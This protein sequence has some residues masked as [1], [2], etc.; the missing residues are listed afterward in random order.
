LIDSAPH[1]GTV[2]V[3]CGDDN[4]MFHQPTTAF[5]DDYQWILQ[6]IAEGKYPHTGDSL[7]GIDRVREVLEGVIK[8][9]E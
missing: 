8:S 2:A 9:L 3:N 5:V 7:P 4:A 6:S 1:V